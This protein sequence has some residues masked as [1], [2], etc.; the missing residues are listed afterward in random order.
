MFASRSRRAL[1]ALAPE[2]AVAALVSLPMNTASAVPS[3][4]LVI[5][6]VYGGGGNAG[7][8]FTHDFIEVKNIGSTTV[9]VSQYSVQYASSAR[10]ATT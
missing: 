2:A 3:A 5:N 10:P 1:A 7:A 4:T 9:D 6:E 8:T